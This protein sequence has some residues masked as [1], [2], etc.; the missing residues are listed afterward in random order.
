MLRQQLS[1]AAPFHDASAIHDQNLVGVLDVVQTM[2]D[3]QHGAITYQRIEA[4]LNGGFR[5]RIDA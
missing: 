5:R 2:G 1:V 3:D 4:P